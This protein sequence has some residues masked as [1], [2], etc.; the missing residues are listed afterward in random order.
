MV[1]ALFAPRAVAL[2]GV[3]DDPA[4]TAARPLLFLRKH[5]YPGAIYP[6]NP[7][8]ATVLGERA[9][10]SLA[11]L[12]GPVDHAYIVV[13]T[14]GVE[15]AVASCAAAKIPVATILAGGF[16]ETGAAGLARQDHLATT[17]ARSGMRL[18]GPNSIGVVN[19]HLP[20]PLTANA[21]FAGDPALRGRLTV[22][23]Q[24]G[25]ALGTLVSRGNPRG[26]GFAKLISVGNEADLSVGEI[27]ALLAE[28]PA[29]DAFLLFL[30]TIRRPDALAQFSELAARAGKPIIAY[31]LGRSA[32]GQELAVSHTGAMIGS[33]AAAD[34]FF[35]RHG[36]IRVDH[37]E[38]LLELPPL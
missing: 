3:S 33:D 38:T 35:R 29:T 31:K 4:K 16:A 18:V 23:S 19:T 20:M 11:E 15:E 28:D 26:I 7:R 25:G 22:I 10:K 24:S 6:I 2:I 30:E 36:I 27:G 5:G 13:N 1:D 17:A 37:L 21:V 32:I 8:R 14:P 12:P 9:Y 34:A